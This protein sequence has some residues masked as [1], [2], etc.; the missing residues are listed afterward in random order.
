MQYA[1][2]KFSS[3][4][5]TLSFHLLWSNYMLKILRIK[6]N[7]KYCTYMIAKLEPI[8]CIVILDSN[9]NLLVYNVHFQKIKKKLSVWVA[10]GPAL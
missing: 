2:D 3:K 9:D 10:T 7:L 4:Q 8:P 1:F 5:N 6:F